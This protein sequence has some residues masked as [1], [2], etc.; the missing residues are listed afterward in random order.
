MKRRV[1]MRAMEKR[2][3]QR[4][5]APSSICFGCGPA[6]E[7]GLQID[8]HRMEGGFVMELQAEPQHQAFPGM[9]NVGII[10]ALLD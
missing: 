4:M 8:S 9:V 10:G 3:V 5:Y 6:N 2:G 1:P 7:Q